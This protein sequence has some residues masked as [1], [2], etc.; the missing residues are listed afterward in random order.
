MKSDAGTRREKDI[1]SRFY[2]LFAAS[3]RSPT[4]RVLLFS[5]W[6]APT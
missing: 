1:D 3:P 6:R 2:I 4:L 5:L